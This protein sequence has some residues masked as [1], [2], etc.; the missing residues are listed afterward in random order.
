LK[1]ERVMYK[2]NTLKAMLREGKV[3]VGI[4]VTLDSSS[5]AEAMAF[6]GFDFLFHCL[7]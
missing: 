1:K 2:I 6:A 3:P 5:A 4:H 7:R